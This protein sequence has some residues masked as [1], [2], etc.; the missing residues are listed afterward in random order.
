MVII[1]TTTL[2][3]GINIIV[4]NDLFKIHLCLI[5]YLQEL[6]TRGKIRRF[7]FKATHIKENGCHVNAETEKI[8][9]INIRFSLIFWFLLLP[10]KYNFCT[11]FLV[12]M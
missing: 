3:I 5:K 4:T 8:M 12:S 1:I 7:E 9:V 10:S 2:I 11:I 6:R